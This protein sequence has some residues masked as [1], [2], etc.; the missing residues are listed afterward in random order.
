MVEL[1]QRN[2][3]SDSPTEALH[4]L[5]EAVRERAGYEMIVLSDQRGDFISGSATTEPLSPGPMRRI[6]LKVMGVLFELAVHGRGAEHELDHV[7]AG[8]QRI[9]A[10]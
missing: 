10:A 1:S 8:A 4:Y 7:L 5:F 9:L 6:P 2:R 3:R